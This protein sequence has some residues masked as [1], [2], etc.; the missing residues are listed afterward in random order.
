MNDNDDLLTC[1]EC[2]AILEAFI[3]MCHCELCT[4]IGGQCMCKQ[5]SLGNNCSKDCIRGI[6]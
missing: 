1:P 5:C 4:A 2:G 6:L 3:P